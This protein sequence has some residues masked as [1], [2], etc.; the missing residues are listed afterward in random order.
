VWKKLRASTYP[1][2]LE[3]TSHNEQEKESKHFIAHN[4][5]AVSWSLGLGYFQHV[6]VLDRPSEEGRPARYERMKIGR[7]SSGHDLLLQQLQLMDGESRS[8]IALEILKQ[9]L[10][11]G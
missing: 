9:E 3:K 2:A 5:H 11:R 10:R 1:K 6:N 8:D 7:S 4:S